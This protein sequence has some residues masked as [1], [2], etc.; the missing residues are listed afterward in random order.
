MLAMV[1][2]TSGLRPVEPREF[3]DRESVDEHWRS[4]RTN[5]VCYEVMLNVLL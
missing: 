5:P 4:V 1:A 3:Y 2:S